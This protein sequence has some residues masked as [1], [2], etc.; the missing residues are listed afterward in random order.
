MS[1]QVSPFHHNVWMKTGVIVGEL[2]VLWFALASP[3]WL[4][5]ATSSDDQTWLTFGLAALAIINFIV[6]FQ[7]DE[8]DD[9]SISETRGAAMRRAIAA[10][11][12][13]TYLILLAIVVFN[14]ELEALAGTACEAPPEGSDATCV[15]LTRDLINRLGVVVIAVVAFYFGSSTLD[16]YLARLRPTADPPATEPEE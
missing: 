3:D 8:D 11:V 10:S 13:L 9:G 5:D 15:A 6:F 4:L 7:S 14:P 1:S 2:V 16:K 12:V